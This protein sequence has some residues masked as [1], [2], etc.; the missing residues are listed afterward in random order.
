MN[1]NDYKNSRD[2]V[3][4]FLIEDG[5]SELPISVS[6]ICRRRGI[7]VKMYDGT[8]EDGYTEHVN[9]RCTIYIST[10]ID[11]VGRRRFTAAHELGHIIL[12]HVGREGLVNREP[13]ERDNPIERAAHVFASRLLAPACVLWGCN[14]YAPEQIMQLCNIS[15]QAAEFRSARMRELRTRGRFLTS[16]LERAVYEQFSSYIEEHRF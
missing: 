15:R 11:N 6:Q 10:S 3:W 2:A 14:A 5:I 12:G 7:L 16:P 4:R 1:Y 8:G 13:S 9:G